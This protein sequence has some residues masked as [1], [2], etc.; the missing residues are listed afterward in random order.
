MDIT[1]T[2]EFEGD[3]H[4]TVTSVK[5]IDS[6]ALTTFGDGYLTALLGCAA[7]AFAVAYRL[8]GRWSFYCAAGL[9]AC[10]LGA[11]LIGLYNLAYDR[12]TSGPGALGISVHVE[13][14]RTAELWILTALA[15]VA[16]A[17]AFFLLAMAWRNVAPAEETAEA[18]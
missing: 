17:A 11:F 13:V 1:F 15:L 6:A 2:E 4:T 7:V 10:S 3:L 18:A 8:T 14:S 16:T 12:A 5:G 9:A